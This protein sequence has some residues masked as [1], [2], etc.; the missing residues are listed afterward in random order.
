MFASAHTTGGEI[1][2]HAL[3]HVETVVLRTGQGVSNGTQEIMAR[4]ALNLRKKTH[5]L[6]IQAAVVS[7]LISRQNRELLS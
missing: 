6:A 2:G 3:K 7:I 1:G 5:Q 4:N